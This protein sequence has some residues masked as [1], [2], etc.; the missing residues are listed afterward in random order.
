MVILTASAAQ[1][2]GLAL[3][4]AEAGAEDPD[5]ADD[6]AADVPEEAA[7]EAAAVA[8][9]AADEEPADAAL[10]AGAAE[11][12]VAELVPPHAVRAVTAA[13]LATSEERLRRVG[14]RRARGSAPAGRF[15]GTSWSVRR[16]GESCRP[17]PEP[18]VPRTVLPQAV[19]RTGACNVAG[20]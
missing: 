13:R 19:R 20:H 7:E 5:G 12:P 10:V 2:T 4:G 6:A 9:P 8:D 3:A 1:A 17:A 14:S 16:M 18:P 11:D 15:M